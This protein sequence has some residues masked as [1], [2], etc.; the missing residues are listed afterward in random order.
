ML[1]SVS[2]IAKLFAKNFSNNSN[3]TELF[4]KS[5]NESCF[6]DCWKVSLVVS[7]FKNIGE[8]TTA[9]KYHPVSLFSVVSKV[10]KNLVN[11]STVDRLE[12]CG[13]FSDFWYRF[14][15]SQSTPDLQTVLCDRIG[16][17]VNRSVALDISKAFDRVWPAGL[18]HKPNY[19]GI[20]AQIFGLISSFISN[21]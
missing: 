12:K 2:D 6:P 16:R 10:F 7:V 4:N 13:L 17:A 21:R 3:F 15:F 18:L 9:K 19:Y 5:L 8:R 14:K 11:N 20:S 1:S